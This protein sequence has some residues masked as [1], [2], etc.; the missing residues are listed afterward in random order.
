MKLL[1]K[2]L[3]IGDGTNDNPKRP[4]LGNLTYNSWGSV[5]E[6][7]DNVHMLLILDTNE[8][9]D[10]IQKVSNIVIYDTLEA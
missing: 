7:T 8:T 4:D 6:T 5:G 9:L 3:L 10:S 1:I 2:T